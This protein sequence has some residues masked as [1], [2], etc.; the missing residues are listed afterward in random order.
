MRDMTLIIKFGHSASRKYR[1]TVELASRFSGFTEATEA[2]P[3]NM[4]RLPAEEWFE[5]KR[6]F[7]DLYAMVS[8]WKGTSVTLDGE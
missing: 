6:E 1:E 8:L 7:D 2:D 3:I 5:K 4:I